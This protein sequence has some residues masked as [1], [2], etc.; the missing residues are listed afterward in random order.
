MSEL[1]RVMG[2]DR[3]ARPVRAGRRDPSPIWDV[4]YEEFTPTD[5]R[6]LGPF[7]G[8]AVSPDTLAHWLDMSVDDALRWWRTHCLL[9]LKSQQVADI[10][11][12]EW[13]QADRDA[14]LADI[15]GPQEIADRLS[16]QVNTVWQWRK[17]DIMPIPARIISGVPL[18]TAE[19]ID[20]W[21]AATGRLTEVEL[22]PF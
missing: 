15:L 17:R 1:D 21:A 16:V 4:W 22:E 10:D 9:E 13:Q 7:M 6:R 14:K 3:L 2:S 19:Q 11:V 8:G 18:W 5:R 12:S 20:G